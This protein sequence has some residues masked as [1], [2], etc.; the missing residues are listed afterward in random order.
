M[1]SSGKKLLQI[2][3]G[4]LSIV[5]SLLSMLVFSKI[6]LRTAGLS[7]SAIFICFLIF[8][9]FPTW[10]KS[11][12]IVI[13]VLVVICAFFVAMA[14][15]QKTSGED[16]EKAPTAE[17]PTLTTTTV[18]PQETS[19][20]PGLISNEQSEK[21]FLD[22]CINSSEWYS[23]NTPKVTTSGKNC[24]QVN[25]FYAK[26]GEGLK[27]II[28]EDSDEPKVGGISHEINDGETISFT[29]RIKN[30][31]TPEFFN[32]ALFVGVS[33]EKEITSS[34]I[35]TENGNFIFYRFFTDGS[36]KLCTGKRM[37]EICNSKNSF[38]SFLGDLTVPQDITI[39]NTTG[40]IT[41]ED[42]KEGSRCVNLIEDY[43]MEGPVYFWVGYYFSGN[44]DFSADISDFE[45][46]GSTP[47]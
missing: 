40:F 41:V 22:G 25:N 12:K 10:R 20:F 5:P 26:E 24:L 8:A 14:V 47:N 29:L 4:I 7:V 38:S 16:G 46:S 31:S 18:V 35:E 34:N 3:L 15:F 36:D 9:V 39:S 44:T 19:T 42:C 1:G 33:N 21:K 2:G 6:W 37:A 45:I 43:P 32:S 11:L 30:Y 13:S 17:E 27:L 23:Y 28:F